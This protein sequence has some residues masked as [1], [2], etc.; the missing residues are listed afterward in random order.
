MGKSAGINREGSGNIKYHNSPLMHATTIDLN[1]AVPFNS[2]YFSFPGTP[3][4]THYDYF[5]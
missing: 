3:V 2:E 4:P 5:N 1:F